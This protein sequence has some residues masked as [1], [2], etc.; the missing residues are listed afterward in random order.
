MKGKVFYRVIAGLL[1]VFV[2]FSLAACTN[3]T[4]TDSTS[5]TST[6]AASSA[7]ERPPL[8]E[9][10]VYY[11]TND[12]VPTF[13]DPDKD[14][15]AKY[16]L[17]KFNAKVKKVYANEGMT[18]SQRINLF[19]ASNSMPDVIYDIN[20]NVTFPSTG[21]V[22][23]LTKL[24]P[25]NCPNLMKQWPK[26]NWTPALFNSM[27]YC[28]PM[29]SVNGDSPEYADDI[30]TRPSGNWG[31][32]YTT[33]KLLKDLGYSFT[34]T[35]DILK[36]VNE[37]QKKPA[38]TELP[39]SPLI[40]TTDDFYNF[41]KQ[42]KTKYGSGVVPFDT[43][44][45]LEPHLGTMFGLTAGQWYYD[46]NS[47][48]VYSS[49]GAANAKTYWK[50]MN[51]LY[52]EGLLNPDFAIE[53]NEQRQENIV[54]G[55]IKCWMY[56]TDVDAV[57]KAV[58][59]KD[60]TDSVR[61]VALPQAEGTTSPGID[62]A[63]QA[64]FRLYINKNFSDIPR[65]LK[66]FDWSMSDE[67]HSLQQWGTEEL[68]LY[69]TDAD[70]KKKFKD[71]SIYE[72][73][74]NGNTEVIDSK[75][76]AYGIYGNSN[77][78]VPG[79]GYNSQTWERSYGFSVSTSDVR[80]LSDFVTKNSLNWTGTLLGGVDEATRAASTW[81]ASVFESQL[82]PKLFAAKSDADFNKAWDEIYKEFMQE[83]NYTKAQSTMEQLFAS[84]GYQV[85]YTKPAK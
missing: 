24:I 29:L 83:S 6:T 48:S 9:Y 79:G 1:S 11:S 20:D 12:S 15:V 2:V 73:L 70:G 28:F 54:S 57:Q 84:R 59:Q 44:I 10:S 5:S 75:L 40:K 23:D 53:T 8:L 51:T 22:A 85:N 21:T 61:C 77:I 56:T 76:K 30:F 71:N 34:P 62:E 63:S 18:K 43:W 26:E 16:I 66:L 46:Q 55:K 65:L 78:M 32:F 19:I 37:T 47:K 36:K 33:E 14:V 82:S 3:T 50:Y 25:E 67:Y 69:T 68:G 58:Q 17:D 74:K 39:I 45:A 42:I 81:Y 72:A 80:Y 64:T 27:L 38:I 49:L 4:A 41:L 60:P 7:S 13:A 52:K 31:G 35:A